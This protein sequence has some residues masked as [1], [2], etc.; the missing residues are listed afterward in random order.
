[1]PN[2]LKCSNC[3]TENPQGNLFCGK[4]GKQ[5]SIPSFSQPEVIHRH[6]DRKVYFFG[7]KVSPILVIG[8]CIACLCLSLVPAVFIP[9]QTASSPTVTQQAVAIT[10]QTMPT[11][12]PEIVVPTLV[13]TNTPSVAVQPTVTPTLSAKTNTTVLT[14][15]PTRTN[16]PIPKPTNTSRPAVPTF[17][18]GMKIVGTDIPPGTYRSMGGN[19]CY[20]ERLRG[21]GGTLD[22]IIAND[23]AIGPALV[24]IS[25]SDKG[26]RS[27]RC[28]RW[29]QDLSPITLSPTAPFSDGTFLVN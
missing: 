8:V 22:E 24:T 26:F 29:T 19:H 2:N 4:C 17:G 9:K 5:L 15:T 16:T 3:G 13:P 6:P 7:R 23:N 20:W 10:T 14:R 28:G 25:A 27:A 21:F 18:E 12:T 11:N 1:M